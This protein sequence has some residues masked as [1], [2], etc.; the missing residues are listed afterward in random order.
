MAAETR[1]SFEDTSGM[2]PRPAPRKAFYGGLVTFAAMLPS[3]PPR[4]PPPLSSAP[5]LRFQSFHS[6]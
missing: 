6:G 1:Q 2:K 3:M 4:P 5:A